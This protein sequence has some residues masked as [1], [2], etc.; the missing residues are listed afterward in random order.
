MDQTFNLSGLL[1]D[2]LSLFNESPAGISATFVMM[3]IIVLLVA[4]LTVLQKRFVARQ[5][6]KYYL[7]QLADFDSSNPARAHEQ[8]EIKDHK[9]YG[10][11]WREFDESLV[12]S[13]DGDRIFNT[14]DADHFFNHQ[15]L[16]HGLISNRLITAVPGFLT[17]IGVL[18]T[19]AGLQMGLSGL[20]LNKD[21]GVDA[22]QAGIGNM[23]SGA[24]I[25]FMTSVW[26][27]L[28]SV[29]FNAGE[30]FIERDVSRQIDHL[31]L[32]ID[33]LY[34]RATAE[35]YLLNIQDSSRE[36]Q[37]VLQG[38]AEKIGEKMQQ[39]MV[40]SGNAI[41]SSL[42]DTLNRI[43]EPAIKSLVQNANS[44]SQD[45]LNNVTERLER[46]LDTAMNRFTE[47]VGAMGAEQKNM[48]AQASSDVSHAVSGMSEQMGDFVQHLQQQQQSQQQSAQQ[49]R[50][51]IRLLL[52]AGQ[53][54]ITSSL[55]QSVESHKRLTD[56]M[57]QQVN[58]S[59]SDMRNR[60]EALASHLQTLSEQQETIFTR[61]ADRLQALESSLAPLATANEQAAQKMDNAANGL[62]LLA[63]QTREAADLLAGGLND[64]TEANRD[65]AVRQSDASQLYQ[66]L[67]NQLETMRS[68][69][70]QT[71]ESLAGAASKAENGFS[72]M[73]KQVQNFVES[74]ADEVEALNEEMAKMLEEYGKAVNAQV[75][76]RMTEWNSHTRNYTDTMNQA[77]NALA[78]VVDDIESRTGVAR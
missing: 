49:E 8:L 11:L 53:Q 18:G 33:A 46:S 3:L 48:M 15:T 30:K 32:R 57:S 64:A 39:A 43:M 10:H 54:Q 55:Q 61:I 65:A 60:D 20:E 22:L 74:L 4:S 29:L 63:S 69:I 5:K 26:G 6:I 12:K 38:L 37:E 47:N 70:Q 77:V 23:I 19:F 78:G 1:P 24:S 62:G 44:G 75:E 41:S 13:H 52:E 58:D 14:L 16:S 56:E 66:S 21:S 76:T 67:F 27:V 68:Q 40:E 2:F 34:P 31:Q 28:L 72:S 51:Q 17:A 73:E 50:E 36:S 9:D 45:L 7:D 35:A 59:L 25:A 71:S 42:E